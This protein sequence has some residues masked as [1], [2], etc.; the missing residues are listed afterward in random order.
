MTL[1]DLVV[2]AQ[3][4]VVSDLDP[5]TRQIRL[6]MAPNSVAATGLDFV[7]SAHGGGKPAIKRSVNPAFNFIDAPVEPK[8]RTFR[9]A[10]KALRDA[11][12][13]LIGHRKSPN[14]HIGNGT[15]DQLQ[16][17]H[18]WVRSIIPTAPKKAAGEI[19]EELADLNKMI[20]NAKKGKGKGHGGVAIQFEHG[21][22]AVFFD[23]VSAYK[24]VSGDREVNYSGGMRFMSGGEA[25][26]LGFRG[27]V[28]HELLFHLGLE[29]IMTPREFRNFYEQI[30]DW[31]YKSRIT[32]ED[33]W[34]P[35]CGRRTRR[36][37]FCGKSPTATTT[38]TS[39]TSSS[40]TSRGSPSK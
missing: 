28:A 2:I 36:R 16:K 38:S 9:G 26:D 18:D 8:A 39:Q 15:V 14:F 27:L 11:L 3:A 24:A 31:L 6:K 7:E 20:A 23:G 19:A 21:P 4:S 25:K 33:Q 37:T 10:E 40:P 34:T 22:S 17:A 1:D 29:R 13:S 35:K 12:Q 32:P 5:K 30:H